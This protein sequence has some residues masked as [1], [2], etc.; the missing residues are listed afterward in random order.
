VKSELDSSLLELRADGVAPRHVDPPPQW[1]GI[2]FWICILISVPAVI[3]RMIA[4]A[5]PSLSAPPQLAALD[6]VFASHATLTLMHILPA[7]AFVLIAPFF[8]LRESYRTA[9]PEYLLFP[10]GTVVAIT[11]YAMS[12]YSIGGWLERSA[13]LLVDRLFLFALARSC[14]FM[15]RG[16]LL[17][18]EVRCAEAVRNISSHR[19]KEG[20]DRGDLE[21]SKITLSMRDREARGQMTNTGLETQRP[22]HEEESSVVL[23]PGTSGKSEDWS[24]VI[25]QL[26]RHR[27]VIPLNYA[28]PVAATHSANAPSMSDFADRVVAAA[29]VGGNH[30]F[31]L[32]GY[33]L[34][35]AVATFIAAEYPDMVR[36]L[37]L[38]SGF[39][40]G[41]DPRMRLQFDLWLHLARTDKIALTKL[42]LVSGLSRQFLSGFDENIINGIIQGF[43]AMSDWTVIEQNIGVDLALDVREQAKKIKSPTLLITGKYDQIVPPFY[44]QELADSIHTAKRA[45]IPSGHLSFLEKPVDLASAMLTFVLEKHP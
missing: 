8:V 25:K 28:E 36:S 35:A 22:N 16:D 40:Y 41:G 42:L 23:L 10:L 29:A 37:V 18:G 30:R 34:G 20:L 12:N 13:V 1:L 45:E 27:R 7:L 32:I 6:Q 3:R 11:A 4:F 17:P 38:E 44:S 15:R 33:S 14:W 43:V 31:D 39:S 2:G 19:W 21:Y 26:T 9:W 24:Q 5:Y